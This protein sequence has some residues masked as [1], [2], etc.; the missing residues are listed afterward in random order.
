MGTFRLEP[1]VAELLDFHRG[2]IQVI[3]HQVE[4]QVAGFSPALTSVTR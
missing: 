1:A 4:V 2:L 3:D